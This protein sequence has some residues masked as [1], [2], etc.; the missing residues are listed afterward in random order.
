MSAYAKRGSDLHSKKRAEGRGSL[1]R[2]ALST[3]LVLGL[4]VDP[5]LILYIWAALRSPAKSLTFSGLNG[6]YHQTLKG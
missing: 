4:T 2:Q 3:W 6:N 1:P 5:Y